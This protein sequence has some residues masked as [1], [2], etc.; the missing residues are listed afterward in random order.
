MA[1][2]ADHVAAREGEHPGEGVVG[3]VAGAVVEIREP[4]QGRVD[5][6]ADGADFGGVVVD[7]D[8]VDAKPVARWGPGFGV[9]H[10]VI[11]FSARSF[12]GR[13]PVGLE[14]EA[15]EIFPPESPAL[16][17]FGIGQPAARHERVEGVQR[18]P[19]ITRRL[20]RTQVGRA[21]HRHIRHPAPALGAGLF[22]LIIRRVIHESVSF[23]L[24]RVLGRLSCIS[25]EI[26]SVKKPLLFL[27]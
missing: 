20:L 15:V 25:G 23:R 24:F 16:A 17:D 4:R 5:A 13:R 26:M 14:D 21:R 6:D 19:Q 12:A 22:L 7:Y 1:D 11:H 9:R 18:H 8:V 27:E 2:D 10:W 3:G